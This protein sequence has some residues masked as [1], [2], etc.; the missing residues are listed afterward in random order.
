MGMFYKRR[1]YSTIVNGK[2]P[3]VA[4]E[5]LGSDLKGK[6]L[7]VIDDMISSGDSMLDVAKQLKARGAGRVFVCTTF[8][9]FTDGFAHFDEYYEK[10]YINK[11]VTTNLTYLPPEV[12]DKPY[13]AIAD[14]SKYIALII[15]SLNHDKSISNVLN[16]T[17]KIHALLE[18]RKNQ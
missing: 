8:G 6:D 11:V 9:L 17:D 13:F 14:M 16:P 4:H 12:N 1:D 2:N 18:K 15:E 5:F 10:G 7:I 3:I